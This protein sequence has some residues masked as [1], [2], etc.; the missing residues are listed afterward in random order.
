MAHSPKI[1][2]AY[3]G[4]SFAEAALIDLQWA[5]LGPKVQA[6]VITVSDFMT[7]AVYGMTLT[8]DGLLGGAYALSRADTNNL[9]KESKA[10]AEK[11][12]QR[13]RKL[14]PGWT[15]SATAVANSPAQGI[16]EEAKKWKPSLIVLGS[17]GHTAL[18]RIF[19]GSVSH[20][21]LR[22]APCN[23]RIA[24]PASASSLKGQRILLAVD[25]SKDAEVMIK[26]VASRIWAKGTE[27]RVVVVFDFPL[28]IHQN[29]QSALKGLSGLPQ[30]L[31]EAATVR[32]AQTGHKVT[33]VTLKGDPRIEIK[34]EVKRFKATSLFVGSR[35]LGAI[36]DFLVG[37]VSMYL[38]EHAPCT[39]EVDRQ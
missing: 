8:T 13:L 3:D 32:L 1:L 19:L 15:V 30:Q 4:S 31:A 12:S 17:L 16:L 23:V 38:A 28:F 21:V 25:G 33:S 7:P 22:H 11:G 20:K 10:L 24:R 29:F 26:R 35:G 36:G 6:R 39:V 14:F 34:R 27:F 2:I 18:A 5:G 37:S 9:L